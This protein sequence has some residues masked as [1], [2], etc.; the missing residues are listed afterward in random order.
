MKEGVPMSSP[1]TV[2]MWMLVVAV[3]C[4]GGLATLAVSPAESLSRDLAGRPISEDLPS[5][6]L[7]RY[8][9]DRL[10]PE[11]VELLLDREPDAQGRV[12]RF[13]VDL[14]GAH[15]GGV[16]VDRFR[17]EAVDVQFNPVAEW[18]G[19]GEDPLKGRLLITGEAFQGESCCPA[20]AAGIDNKIDILIDKIGI[21]YLWKMPKKWKK[22]K[23]GVEK[24]RVKAEK[25]G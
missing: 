14:R 23:Q 11:S 20:G 8:L 12:G 17:V 16:R 21:E 24:Y 2:G 5:Q 22:K 10:Q 15:L 18:Q 1:R 25:C 19:S 3:L 9:V 7:L 4:G 13:Y 6:V